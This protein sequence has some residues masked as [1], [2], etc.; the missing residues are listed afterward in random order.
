M[1]NLSV[2]KFGGTSVKNLGRV[3]HVARLLAT[4]LDDNPDCKQIVIVSAMGDSTDYLI[5]LAKRC[6]PQPDKR[7]LDLLLSTG[8]QTAIALL[9]LALKSIGVQARSY[10]GHQL[11]L[12]TDTT[13]GSARILGINRDAL[14]RAINDHD[15]IV[16]AGFQGVTEEGEI[17]TLGRGGSDTSAVALA[18][19][20][21]ATI[22]DIFTDVDGLCS[23]DPNVVT[24]TRLLPAVT[25]EEALELARSGAQV[26]HP[27]AVELANDYDI[28]LRIRNTFNP[29]EGGTIITS[30]DKMER[31]ETIAGVAIDKGQACIR[32]EDVPV[33]SQVLDGLTGVLARRQLAA[34]VVAQTVNQGGASKNVLLIVK[35][36]DADDALSVV[37]DLQSATA[38]ERALLDLEV[39]KVSL[40]GRGLA[41]DNRLFARVLSSL[42]LNSVDVQHVTC[43]DLRISCFVPRA[44]AQKAS[45]VIHDEFGLGEP[46]TRGRELCHAV[47]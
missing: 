1:S 13:F 4:N 38:A 42:R 33:D 37:A 6:S 24:D 3:H 46:S 23:A 18:A 45:Q 9:A 25:Y 43:S 41:A 47:A 30:E 32:L 28:T 21:G 10:T 27:R 17:T 14:S 20:C 7:E 34:D 15:V 12:L 26:I 16:V 22:C 5:D 29:N 31:F 2:L 39:C 8:E 11:G 40:V 19:A 35:Y 36:S 44:Q